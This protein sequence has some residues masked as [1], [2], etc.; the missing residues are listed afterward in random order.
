MAYRPSRRMHHGAE[1]AD[2]NLIPIM[3]V[4]IIIIPFLLLTVV[5]AKTAVIDVYLPHEV[6]SPP[7]KET[8]QEPGERT[9]PRLLTVKITDGALTVGWGERE[10]RIEAAP[11]NSHLRRLSEA[12]LDIKREAPDHREIIL[13][14]D[15]HISYDY[16]VKVMDASREITLERGGVKSR[17]SLFPLVSLGENRE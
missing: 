14:F 17:R 13:L 10:E 1:G 5:F 11:D 6:E 8:E 9:P 7:E 15:S 12:L 4:F 3:N 2:L 16:V